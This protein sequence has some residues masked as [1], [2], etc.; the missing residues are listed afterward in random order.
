MRLYIFF[1]FPWLVVGKEII[2]CYS[3]MMVLWADN[4]LFI[5]YRSSEDNKEYS[6]LA[7]PLNF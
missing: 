4:I 5:I 3:G 6:S 1:L 2:L 7:N